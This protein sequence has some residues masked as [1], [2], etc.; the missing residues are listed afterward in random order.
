MSSLTLFSPFV[1]WRRAGL[2]GS[3]V[4]LFGCVEEAVPN[5]PVV[6]EAADTPEVPEAADAPEVPETADA[7]EVPEAADAPEV[8]EA[9]DA[10][11]P[12]ENMTGFS[13]IGVKIK[14]CRNLIMQ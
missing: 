12:K 4:P 3:T 1:H 7:P 14:Q 10:P 11:D 9:A 8:P 5:A 2:G 13:R 6:P